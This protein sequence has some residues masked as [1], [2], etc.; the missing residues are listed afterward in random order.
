M[1]NPVIEPERSLE[2]KSARAAYSNLARM[3]LFNTLCFISDAIG[4]DD[5]NKS[6]DHILQMK[7]L[8]L[9]NTPQHAAERQQAFRLLCRHFKFIKYMNEE[10]EK[11]AKKGEDY[12]KVLEYDRFVGILK[13]A[14]TVLIYYRDQ[15][16][17]HV[18]RDARNTDTEYLKA[19]ELLAWE[20]DTCFTIAIR[21]IKERFVKEF[22]D[23][24][25]KHCLDFLNGRTR[26]NKSTNKIVLNSKHPYALSKEDGEH[27]LRLTELGK[28]FLLSLFIQKQYASELLDKC[29]IFE[30]K[31]RNWKEYAPAGSPQQSYIRDIFSALRV[32]LP[33]DRIDSTVGI[34]QIG[35]DMLGELKRCPKELFD[36]LDAKDRKVFESVDSTTGEKVLL[37]RSSDRFPQLALSYIDYTGLFQSARFAVNAGRY[38]YVF[39]E[40]KHCI[41]GTTEPRILQKDL[42]GFGRIQEI[43]SIRTLSPETKDNPWPFQQLV[44]GFEDT[45]KKDIDCCPYIQD[46]KTRYLF[47]GDHIGIHFGPKPDGFPIEYDSFLKKDGD[48]IWYLPEITASPGE[49]RHAKAPC[50]EPHCWL[51]VYDIP[52]MTFLA[53]LTRDKSFQGL[54]HVERIILD[55]VIRYRTLF[56]AIADGTVF[57]GAGEDIEQHVKTKYGIT[58]KDIPKSLQR[59]LKKEGYDAAARF[60]AH[61]RRM[62]SG[63]SKIGVVGLKEYNL[64]RID[65]WD[66]DM[67]AVR[68]VKENKAGKD[69]FVEIKVGSLMSWVLK[70][71][72]SL[73]KYSPIID[74]KTG[75]VRSNKLTG[76]NYSKLQ[77]LLS[78]FPFKTADELIAIFKEYGL[79]NTHP[80]L[81]GAIVEGDRPSPLVFYENYIN[82]RQY[83]FQDLEEA[84]KDG[85]GIGRYGFVKAERRKWQADYMKTLPREFYDS[86][87]SRFMP[88]YLP[89]GLFEKALREQL[90]RIPQLRQ[91]LSEGDKDGRKANTTYMIQKYFEIVLGDGPQPYYSFKRTYPFHDYI[92]RKRDSIR[93]SDIKAKDASA[94]TTNFRKA[95]ETALRE[96]PKID[97]NNKKGGN[98]RAAS[99]TE[100]TPY[101]VDTLRR[102]WNDMADC[103]RTLR[104]YKVQDMLLFMLGSSIVFP[105]D[106]GNRHRAEGFLLRNVMGG[107]EGKD[108]LSLPVDISTTV[109]IKQ[110]TYTVV[111]KGVKVRD[112]SEVFAILRDS[113]TVSLLPI[114]PV[115]TVD[116]EELRD[117]LKR[118]DHE[119]PKVFRDVLLFEKR[120]YE[121]FMSNLKDGRIDFKRLLELTPLSPEK[122]S[123]LRAI[124]NAFSHNSY[125]QPA[126]AGYTPELRPAPERGPAESLEKKAVD[127]INNK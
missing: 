21:I 69:G 64:R 66:A 9:E 109:K 5:P 3:N 42:N 62:I 78:T 77:G 111:Q 18:F 116:A 32:S 126:A 20:L 8:S 30:E 37:R 70:D 115:S 118:Y 52:A 51:S 76:L 119:R 84:L 104:R 127:I 107:N 1:P 35:I 38:R 101:S 108:I 28:V 113:R 110:N 54:Q 25:T 93:L 124:R 112:Y 13:R 24:R 94:G 102:K 22:K 58:F 91:A 48:L 27:H 82:E 103:E 67:K 36:L 63:E 87:T 114:L 80:F 47:N 34:D 14:I 98:N 97:R 19:E 105:A 122:K 65:R 7:V 53:F 31:D 83:F 56:K 86:A 50:L 125:A 46:A 121:R 39:K 11:R 26:K 2:M 44:K 89:S 12:I 73:Q 45:P 23:E 90:D 79:W 40:K 6:E 33:H 16:T 68:D 59:F 75:I 123:Q 120:A 57:D 72:V 92:D 29:K 95:V 99:G 81:N 10:D 88:V 15:S 41:D 100:P 96:R 85:K 60:R 43:E 49:G 74:S 71:I 17:H 117:E 106:S 61:L 4:I 55:C